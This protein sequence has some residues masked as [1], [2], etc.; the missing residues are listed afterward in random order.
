MAAVV[1]AAA[2]VAA[3]SACSDDGES[4]SGSTSTTAPAG[5][6]A[7]ES[8]KDRFAVDLPAGWEHFLIDAA[9]IE[10]LFQEAGD[11]IDQ[12]IANQIRTLVGRRGVLFAYDRAHRTTNLNVLKL[13]STPGTTVEQLAQSLPAELSKELADVTVETVTLASGTAVKAT[14]SKPLESGK[15]LFQLQYYVI[16]GDALFITVLAT[17]DAARDR[18]ALE[19]IGQ[20]FGL[21]P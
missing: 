13:T 15:R 14:G 8:A 2:M 6:H 18:P 1:V 9:T 17:D 5:P 20:S 4:G 7:V 19:G 3:G 11:K 16:A 10:R 21:L 12:A